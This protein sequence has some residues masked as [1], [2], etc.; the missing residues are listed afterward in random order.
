MY[1]IN[2]EEAKFS[3]LKKIANLL[4]N[5]GVMLYPTDTVAGIGC[6]SDKSS[7][8]H[9]VNKIKRRAPESPV[10]LAFSSISMVKKFVNLSKG[11]ENILQIFARDKI[12]FIIPFAPFRH[13]LHY[14][15]QEKT[16][17]FRIINSKK[18]NMIIEL[19]GIPI[20]STSANISGEIPA[21]A[22]SKVH[23]TIKKQMDICIK[24]RDELSQISSTIIKVDKNPEIIRRGE[25]SKKKLERLSTMLSSY[26]EE[27]DL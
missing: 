26:Q 17:G 13:T 8:I 11:F 12:T 7:L 9:R 5:G 24:W 18:I 21:Q 4:K 6:R 27:T 1:A 2:L 15:K 25:L 3:D 22:F 19:L 14:N 23:K 10:T 16:I 20:I